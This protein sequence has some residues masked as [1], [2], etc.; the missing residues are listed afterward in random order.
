MLRT[1]MKLVF[2]ASAMGIAAG[3]LSAGVIAW[4]PSDTGDT[5]VFSRNL[6]GGSTTTWTSSGGRVADV[7]FDSLTGQLYASTQGGV[8][9]LNPGGSKTSLGIFGAS[10]N[11]GADIAIRNGVIAWSPSDTGDTRVFSR[12]LSGGPTTTWTSS[13]GRVADV[14]FDN[15]TGQLYASTQGGVFR[16]N[17]G[18]SKTSLGIFGASYNAGADIA[19]FS[20]PPPPAVPEPSSLILM[21]VCA[22][23]LIGYRRTASTTKKT[24]E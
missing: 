11:A 21:G 3:Q 1:T 24:P 20:A 8:F 10:Y 13:G 2:F 7:T 19:V 23:G 6:S 18:G 5:R 14:A 22:I 9:R 4:S 17:P 16:L 12:N 15:L